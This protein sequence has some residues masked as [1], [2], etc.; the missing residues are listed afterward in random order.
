M[1]W[2]N[3]PEKYINPRMETL[4]GQKKKK[5]KNDYGNSKSV[6]TKIL[7]WLAFILNDLL[8]STPHQVQ[9]ASV[10]VKKVSN[11]WQDLRS[12]AKACGTKV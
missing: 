6:S 12:K 1:A 9:L 11:K 10:Q 2:E 8:L 5:K 3:H 4:I 7:K